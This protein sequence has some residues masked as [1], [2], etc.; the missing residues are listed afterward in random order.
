M[1]KSWWAHVCQLID[2]T[3]NGSYAHESVWDTR[4]TQSCTTFCT[5][6]WNRR[7]LWSRGLIPVL[8]VVW[9]FQ[10]VSASP[11]PSSP[12]V[13]HRHHLNLACRAWP[14]SS[15][16][17]RNNFH[18]WVVVVVIMMAICSFVANSYNLTVVVIIIASGERTRET[19]IV[20]VT[21]NVFI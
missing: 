11:F 4:W 8:N 15:L 6:Y 18:H 1:M 2:A 21:T 9:T 13:N 14:L 5:F 12:V 17:T 7:A 20:K 16:E 3:L 10:L 19:E